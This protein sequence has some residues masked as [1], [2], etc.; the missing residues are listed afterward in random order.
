MARLSEWR[1]YN[2]YVQS[3][4]VDGQFLNASFTL[5][6]AGPPRLANVG[7][8]N[9]VNTGLESGNADEI[10]FPIGVVQNFNVAHTRQF[11]RI[12]EIG[13]ERSFW[14]SGRT[15]GQMGLS[16][17][18]YHGPSLLRVLYAYYQDLLPGSV[19][20]PSVI[21]ENNLGALTVANAHDVKIPPGYENLYLNLA[22]DLFA[23]PVGI[24]AYFRDS[25][26]ET[27]GAVYMES[28][29]IPNHTIA[30]D[31]NGTIIQE[32]VAVQFERA[33]PVAVAALSL[34]GLNAADNEV[35]G[36]DLVGQ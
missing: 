34:V 28:C 7:G 27:V 36:L 18:M 24:M 19:T 22:S 23:Q 11:S 12:F 8:A 3:G 13:S 5:L 14:I 20:V 30:T 21:G 33:L 4:L 10:V 16:R 32:D 17:V 6:A 25:N 1:P 9:F 29:V 35:L 15:M 26:E 2:R 31:A